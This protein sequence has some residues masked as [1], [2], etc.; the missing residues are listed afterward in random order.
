MPGAEQAL[1]PESIRPA[2][3]TDFPQID[4]ILHAAF[5]TGAEAQLVRRL[6]EDGALRLENV[7]VM[8]GRVIG[9]IAFSN[10]EVSSSATRLAAVALAPLSVSPEHQKAGIGSRLVLDSHRRLASA[11]IALSVVLGHPGYYPRFGYSATCA[12]Q[13]QAPYSGPSFMAV[14]L[15][16]SC[17]ENRLWSVSYARAFSQ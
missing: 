5:G 9:H 6:R 12:R 15:R 8:E 4:A 1:M 3:S 17:L 10:L 11:N 7:A 13:L 2:E 14:E 16:H